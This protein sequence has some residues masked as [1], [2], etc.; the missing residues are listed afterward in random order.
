MPSVQ[1]F[2]FH[3]NLEVFE[4]LYSFVS[5]LLLHPI[6]IVLPVYSIRIIRVLK[7][8]LFHP[9]QTIADHSNL[10]V[11]E[12]LFALLLWSVFISQM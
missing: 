1:A 8:Y 4:V 7:Y 12:M 6:C 11:F 10:R 9:L 2:A 5:G 3:L